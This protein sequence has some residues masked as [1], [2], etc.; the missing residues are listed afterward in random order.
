MKRQLIKP[1]KFNVWDH[2][3]ERESWTC[4]ICDE[5][6]ESSESKLIHHLETK[7]GMKFKE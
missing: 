5:E 1:K 6:I 3:S 2:F 4:R 7:H